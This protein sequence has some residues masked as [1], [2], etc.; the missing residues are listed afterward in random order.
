MT[1]R[2]HGLTMHR[3]Y[4]GWAATT[5]ELTI[6]HASWLPNRAELIGVYFA[7][8]KVAKAKTQAYDLFYEA[9]YMP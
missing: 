6:M 9:Q 8:A 5:A 7:K 3:P 4:K 1:I 2:V